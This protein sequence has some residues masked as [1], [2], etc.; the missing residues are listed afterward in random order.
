MI[1]DSWEPGTYSMTFRQL[2]R[3]SLE[4]PGWS[5]APPRSWVVG[6]TSIKDIVF[7]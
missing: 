2:E 1:L 5:A 7:I 4:D 3:A 6:A